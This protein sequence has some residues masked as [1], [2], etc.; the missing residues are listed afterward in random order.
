L[1]RGVMGEAC[2]A[3]PEAF[4]SQATRRAGAE[5]LVPVALRSGR[6]EEERRGVACEA[7]RPELNAS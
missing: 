4:A 3:R 1:Q 6:A 2:S 5:R 7:T